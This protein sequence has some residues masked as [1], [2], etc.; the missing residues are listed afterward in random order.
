VNEVVKEVDAERHRA[1]VKRRGFDRRQSRRRR[2][3]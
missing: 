1:R 2:R 3:V